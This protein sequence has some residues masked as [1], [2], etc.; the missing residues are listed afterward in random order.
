M[1]VRAEFSECVYVS[2]VG[3][4]VSRDVPG[5][6]KLPG[7]ADDYLALWN[8]F[9]AFLKESGILPLYLPPSRYGPSNHGA[10]F[11][12]A[13]G[14]RVVEWLEGRGLSVGRYGAETPKAKEDADERRNAG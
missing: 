11:T 13:D 8:D 3:Q 6:G 2:I 12:P 9:T 7:P 14:R 4:E 1:S 10:A 5:L